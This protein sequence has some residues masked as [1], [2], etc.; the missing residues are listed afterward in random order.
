MIHYTSR[1]GVVGGTVPS[2]QPQ[3]RLVQLKYIL[4]AGDTRLVAGYHMIVF[5]H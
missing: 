1:L 3:V 5:M 4:Q 2:H